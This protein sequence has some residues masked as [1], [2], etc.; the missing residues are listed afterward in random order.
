MDASIVLFSLVLLLLELGINFDHIWVKTQSVL[1]PTKQ[2]N[3]HILD[4]ADLAGP[5]VFCFLFGVCLLLV[6]SPPLQMT[7]WNEAY[8]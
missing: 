2:I 6:R 7:V 5:L 1:L 3:E 4:D 8:M